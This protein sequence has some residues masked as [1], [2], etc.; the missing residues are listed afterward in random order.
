MY[1][2][3]TTEEERNEGLAN[4]EVRRGEVKCPGFKV[5]RSLLKRFQALHA[6]R[7]PPADGY[8]EQPVVLG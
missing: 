2:S 6:C 1:N 8:D 4:N 5:S 7:L 3:K